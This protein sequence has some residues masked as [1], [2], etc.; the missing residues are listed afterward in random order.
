MDA[1]QLAMLRVLAERYPADLA[2]WLVCVCTARGFADMV[3]TSPPAGAA[4]LLD[5][6]NQQINQAGW[7]L[8]PVRRN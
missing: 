6:I 8:V 4:A 2:R 7:E 3:S 1:A 5:L